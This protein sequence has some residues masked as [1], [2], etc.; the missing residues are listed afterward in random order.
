MKTLIVRSLSGGA[1]L[2][3]L[4]G[5]S[6]CSTTINSVERADPVGQRQMVNDKRLLTDASLNRKVRIIGLN[7]GATPAGLARIN[8]EIMNMTR[9]L[10]T[11]NYRV[12]WYDLNG[13]P[14]ESASA[15]WSHREILGKETLNITFTA[16]NP[17]AKD[18]R[19]KFVE[20][21]R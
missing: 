14:V 11:F 18:F 19:V 21:L 12:E 15:G 10:Q 2:A 1:L 4:L 13:L 17:A 8:V 3:A 20:D 5:L 6:G 7:E 16:P 9:S